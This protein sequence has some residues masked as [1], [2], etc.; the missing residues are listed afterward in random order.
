MLIMKWTLRA[1]VVA[2]ALLLIFSTA[3]GIGLL[4]VDLMVGGIYE[5][6]KSACDRSEMH[7]IPV[8]HRI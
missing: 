4:A 5:M 2:T 7:H 8:T 1:L 6:R 3:V